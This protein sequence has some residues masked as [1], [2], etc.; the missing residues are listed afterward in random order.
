[1]SDQNFK[2]EIGPFSLVSTS[3][4]AHPF[5]AM[6]DQLVSDQM[7]ELTIL[8]ASGPYQHKFDV[9]V[10]HFL[11]T[12]AVAFL[13]A[14]LK[15][16]DEG[17]RILLMDYSEMVHVQVRGSKVHMSIDGAI[18]LE[19]FDY[20]QI[21]TGTLKLLQIQVKRAISEG[22]TKDPDMIRYGLDVPIWHLS[23]HVE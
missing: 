6:A 17:A 12:I 1:M 4:G 5:S 18:K 9:S 16:P 21:L 11:E 20:A 10:V 19:P 7:Y 2:I 3:H 13:E 22:R 15:N 23:D 8:T 14:L